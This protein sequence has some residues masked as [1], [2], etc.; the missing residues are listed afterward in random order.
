MASMKPHNRKHLSEQITIAYR[1]GAIASLLEGSILPQ[2][3][4][5]LKRLLNFSNSDKQLIAA[6]QRGYTN[7]EANK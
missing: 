4:R 7:M 1:L 3:N 2:S 5:K 6:Y